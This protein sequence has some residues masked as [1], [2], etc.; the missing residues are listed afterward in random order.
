MPGFYATEAQYYA[1]SLSRFGGFGVDIFFGISGFLIT[2]LLLDEQAESGGISIAAFYVRRAF[3]ILPPCFLY[4]AVVLITVGV[5]SRLEVFSVLFFFRNYI[6]DM[7]GSHATTHLWSLAVEEQFYLLWPALLVFI[8]LHR[9]PKSRAVLVAWI[10]VACGLWR[11]ADAQNQV[12]ERFLPYVPVHFR[13]DLRMDALLWGCFAAFLMSDPTMRE[14]LKNA[15][16]QRTFVALLL[17]GLVCVARYSLLTGLWLPMVIPL[18][19][20]G[21]ILHPEWIISRLLDHPWVR[22]IGRM[23]YSLYLWQ[24]LFLVSGWEPRL[25]F[26]KSPQNL[27]LIF[28]CAVLSYK[29]VEKPCMNF[30]R[31]LS[32]G[33]RSRQ[34]YH[35][36]YGLSTPA[37]RPPA[38]SG[39]SS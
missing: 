11:I 17:A 2:K 39:S 14:R 32:A 28:I 19:L 34:V 5:H 25:V 26:Q 23:S 18:L 7:A 38:L 31:K 22:F 20:M 29:L 3:R 4:L 8:V 13:T 30:G 15:F 6:P 9:D 1:D 12:T 10:S 37:D 24:Q 16:H 36:D 33:I 21:T 27:I 35:H